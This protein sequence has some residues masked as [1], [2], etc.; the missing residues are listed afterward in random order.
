MHDRPLGQADVRERRRRTG[1]LRDSE[2][3]DLKEF[4]MPKT[5]TAKAH[6]K[7]CRA[8]E[9]MLDGKTYDQI[10]REV[11]YANRG[12]AHRVVAKALSERLADDIDVLRA[13]EGDRLEAMLCALWPLALDGDVRAAHTVLKIID[14]EARLYGLY[15]YAVEAQPTTLVMSPERAARF[16]AEQAEAQLAETDTDDNPTTSSAGSA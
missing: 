5:T 13:V 7:A 2:E 15:N 3:R 4:E 8:V 6:W 11:G 12:T 9:L 14:T 16:D 1:R 10:A